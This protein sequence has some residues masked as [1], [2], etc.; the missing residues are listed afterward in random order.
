MLI[1][2]ATARYAGATAVSANGERPREAGSESYLIRQASQVQPWQ[3]QSRAQSLAPQSGNYM[4]IQPHHITEGLT[5][6]RPALA[7]FG[8]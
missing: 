4:P 8:A 7:A 3:Q 6:P 2:T 1:A 5:R